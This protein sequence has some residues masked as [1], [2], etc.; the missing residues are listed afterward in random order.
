MYQK[1]DV[2]I[3]GSGGAGL[4]A[5][6]QLPNASVAVLTKV[7]PT[8]SHTG[9]AQGG[10][11]AALGNQEEDHWKWHMYDTVK[12]GDYLVDQPAAE[13][14]AREAIDAV[15]ELEH[16]GLPF[17]RT[18]DGRIDQ[19]RFGGHTRNFGEGP[20]RR[21]CYAADRT[22]HMIL[23]TMYQSA[24]KNQVRFFNE[25]LVLDLLFN[26]GVACGVVA[27]EIRTGEIHT[28]HAKTIL[29]ATGGYGRAWRVTSN[30]FA[31]MGDGMSI[32]YRRGIPLQ[33]MEMYQFHPT[34]IYK[35]GVLLSEAARGEGGKLLNDKGEYFM[36]RYMPTL[37]DLA[38]RDIVSRCIVQ[39]VNEGRGI[40]GKD[41]VYLDVRHLGAKVI[42]EK[43]PDITDFA[44][45]YLGVEP[46]TEPVPIQPTAHYAMGGIPTDVDARVVI[47]DQWTP[48]PGF[49]AAGEV[50]C[51]SVHGAN[52]LGTNSLVDLIVFGRRAGKHMA[53]F[54]AENDHAPLP[55]GYEEH[56]RE[57]VDRLYSSTGNESATRIRSDLQNMMID[58]VF[59]ERTEKGLRE[60]LEGID[61][62]QDAYSKVQ[63]Q[64]KGKQFNTEL[65]EAVELGFLLDCAEATI[66]GALAR[67]E[68]RGAHFRLDYPNRDDANWLKH[69]L[70]YKG[71]GAHDVR[72]E[73]KDVILI[74]DPIFKPKER[75][76]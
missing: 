20:V 23:Q 71:T 57:L 65:V 60:S 39:E 32:A 12:G 58:K 75:K 16:R 1:F 8:R 55:T 64:D 48:Q 19:R 56:S 37:K 66:H 53:K 29:F 74:D 31:C 5:A 46:I 68:S 69:T 50:A 52:R 76:Y 7:Y 11:A 38:P 70:A 47:D 73:Y 35:V 34:G 24:I 9:A 43:L 42:H 17:N 62:L 27:L 26:D 6:M 10:V 21:S 13:I 45:N 14:L 67:T 28:F 30:A 61:E 59:V 41:Y 49:Y 4:M 18:A 22:G 33:D 51:V 3:V 40:N 25:F 63:L 15:Y 2:V 54:I 72:L 36:E 44:R